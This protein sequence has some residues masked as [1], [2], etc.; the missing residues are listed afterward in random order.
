MAEIEAE[1]GG[2]PWDKSHIP[3]QVAHTIQHYDGTATPLWSPQTISAANSAGSEIV[4][5]TGATTLTMVAIGDAMYYGK[6][7]DLQGLA[8]ATGTGL[9]PQNAAITI[10]CADGASYF[11]AKVTA[12]V[13]LY[14][15]FEMLKTPT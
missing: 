1:D 9:L 2:L 4:I 15:H 6:Q 14:F 13:T 10:P 11:V 8:K 3:I 7:T 5:P 12:N